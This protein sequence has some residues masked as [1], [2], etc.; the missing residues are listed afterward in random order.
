[1]PSQVTITQVATSQICNFPSGNLLK[2]HNSFRALQ[3]GWDRG[4]SAEARTGYG[5]K[6]CDSERLGKLPFGKM[7]LGKY[8]TLSLL[9]YL[10]TRIRWGGSI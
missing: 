4:P 8:L 3:L 2:P 7:H 9:G 5:D 10:K 1:M 6:H